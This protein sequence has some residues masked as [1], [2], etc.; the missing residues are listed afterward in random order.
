MTDTCAKHPK[1]ETLVKC[2]SCGVPICDRCMSLTP[3]GYKCRACAGGGVREYERLSVPQAL[4]VVVIGLGV[5][6]IAGR[7]L[8]F[9]GFFTLFVAPA[10]GRAVGTLLL[11]VSGHKSGLLMECLSGGAIFLGGIT[12][13]TVTFILPL[14]MRAHLPAALMSSVITSGVY[15]LLALALVIVGVVSRLRFEIGGW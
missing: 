12:P 4:A 7:F 2:A 10:A 3:V 15:G 1:V 8:Q 11:K 9:L 14:I 13:L 5:G 6:V